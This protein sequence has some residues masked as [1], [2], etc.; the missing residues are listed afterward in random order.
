MADGDGHWFSVHSCVPRMWGPTHVSAPERIPGLPLRRRLYR[1]S[2]RKLLSSGGH[3]TLA[4]CDAV[5]HRIVIAGDRAH[6]DRPLFGDELAAFVLRDE[7]E[8]LTVDAEHGG[9]RHDE[10]FSRLPDDPRA[11]EL[12]RSHGAVGIP[13]DPLDQNRLRVLVDVRRDEAHHG[14]RQR[15]L[16]VAAQP[17]ERQSVLQVARLLDRDV[18]I[19][20]EQLVLIDRRQHGLRRHQMP[21]ADRHVADDARGRRGDG[22]VTQLHLLLLHLRLQRLE[23]RFSGAQRRLRLL[24]LLLADRAGFVELARTLHLLA[25]EGDAGVLRGELRLLARDRRLLS[26]R[27]DL[28]ERLAVADAVARLHED[29]RDLAVGLRLDGR[30]AQRFQGRDVL[31]RVFDGP[32]ARRR[33]RHRRRGHGRWTGR[34]LVA[35]ARERGERDERRHRCDAWHVSH[36]NRL[37]QTFFHW[38]SRS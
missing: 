16:T 31:G 5:E 10:A 37:Y 30:R 21:D 8:V 7:R 11:D 12:R 22:V 27:I 15:L 26:P 23:I 13:H 19:D 24:E 17:A 32:R 25:R 34:G 20:L 33:E 4:G 36:V 6:L 38:R 28:E 29:L 14:R 9:N 18:H 2:I 1:Y 3:N 35:I